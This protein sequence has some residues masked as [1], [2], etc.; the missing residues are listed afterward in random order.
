[1]AEIIDSEK[2]FFDSIRP[3]GFLSVVKPERCRWC[4]NPFY[5]SF[6]E[7]NNIPIHCSLDCKEEERDFNRVQSYRRQLNKQNGKENL[8]TKRKQY[9]RK[10]RIKK[11]PEEKKE[12]RRL[13]YQTH[14]EEFAKRQR[15]NRLKKK[16][17]LLC[18]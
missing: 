7:S 8:A 3:T 2:T 13:Y 10:P 12:V 17:K 15:S 11:T 4:R 5:P 9:K 14:K 1:M 6:S 16:I 18:K